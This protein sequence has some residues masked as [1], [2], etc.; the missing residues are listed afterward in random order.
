MHK[1]EISVIIPNYNSEKFISQ[2]LNSI[3]SQT[4]KD[5]ELIIA[6]DGSI[7]QSLNIIKAIAEKDNR[8]KIIELEHSGN[9]AKVVN[10]AFKQAKG[11][12]LCQVDSD[13]LIKQ[14]CLEKSYDFIIKNNPKGMIYTDHSLI[15]HN[16]QSLGPGS[17]CR[18]TYSKETILLNFMTFHFRLFHQSIFDKV[19]G[20]DE[21]FKRAEDY[22][23]CL[24]V[25]EITDIIKLDEVLY[26][27]RIHTGQVT[28]SGSLA[29]IEYS[30]KAIE[31]AMKRR[32][33]FDNYMLI[34]KKYKKNNFYLGKY[35]LMER[36]TISVTQ[37]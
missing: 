25:S 14:N 6:D 4:Y 29:I 37:F 17:R 26:F 32:G 36:G 1:P 28:Q 11:T 3:L 23:F 35:S 10:S 9:L 31:N 8:V 30:Y 2:T 13:D 21:L 7:D 19:G 27:Y 22:D 20:F 24:R 5:F 16:N 12:Y 15:D 33:L 34:C 18:L